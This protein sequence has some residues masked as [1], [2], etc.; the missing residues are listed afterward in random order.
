MVDQSIS[1]DAIING[2]IKA[3]CS[4]IWTLIIE[5]QIKPLVT[6][7]WTSIYEPVKDLVNSKL[8]PDHQVRMI[9][10]L[11]LKGLSLMLKCMDAASFIVVMI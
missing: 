3:T 4:L 1:C 2:D 7:Q 11:M 10:S 5:Y 8:P 6:V 9:L